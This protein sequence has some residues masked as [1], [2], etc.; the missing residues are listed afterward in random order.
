[1]QTRNLPLELLNHHLCVMLI[2][3]LKAA[4]IFHVLPLSLRRV[5]ILTLTPTLSFLLLLPLLL[6]PRLSHLEL[7][8]EQLHIVI[9]QLKDLHPVSTLL[10]LLLLQLPKQ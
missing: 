3:T 5:L 1:M 7:L 6:F 10:L 4:C 2:L 8:A 9:E